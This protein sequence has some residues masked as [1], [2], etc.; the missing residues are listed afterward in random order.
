MFGLMGAY[1]TGS[2]LH[3][4][5]SI[6]VLVLVSA[7]AIASFVIAIY[8]GHISKKKKNQKVV[9]HNK[10]QAEKEEANK[11][12]REEEQHNK[13][14][15]AGVTDGQPHATQGES[16]VQEEANKDMM[17]LMLVGILGASVTYLTGL[18][19]PGGL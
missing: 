6:I 13:N 8:A 16:S 11:K 9:Q 1:S 5:T 7:L 2:Y 19:P 3:L 10:T 14:Q 15:A 17:Y 4:R 18:K 12:K